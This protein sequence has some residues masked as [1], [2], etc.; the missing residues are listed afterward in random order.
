MN[1]AMNPKAILICIAMAAPSAWADL[2]YGDYAAAGKD[3]PVVVGYMTGLVSG[4]HL[5]N[6][7]V[8]LASGKDLF[9]LPQG[10][11]ITLDSAHSLVEGEA[12]KFEPASR[13]ELLIPPLLMRGVKTVYACA[14]ANGTFIPRN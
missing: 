3:H 12:Q 6:E 10:I 7:A 13:K 9:C 4:V 11:V 5:A 1:T 14:P 2:K 8:L